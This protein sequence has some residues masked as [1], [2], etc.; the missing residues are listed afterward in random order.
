M[1]Y[2]KEILDKTGILV[3]R[4][5]LSKENC[6]KIIDRF[7]RKTEEHKDGELARGYD[8]SY[9]VTTDWHIQEK[10]LDVLLVSVLNIAHDK[11]LKYY[12]HLNKHDI[13]YCGFQFQKSLKG[14]GTFHW[15]TDD[16]PANRR[17][18]APIF[19]LNDVDEGG[20]TSFKYQRIKIKPQAGTLVIFP[21]TWTYYHKGEI[22]LSGDKYIIT[23][24]GMIN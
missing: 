3:F 7:Y 15:H 20:E 6:K 13:E 23:T 12:S 14:K 16:D 9:K 1:Q 24:F 19:Y 10:D 17:I 5:A 11:L 21:A 8:P 4:N 2:D 18:L 22:P